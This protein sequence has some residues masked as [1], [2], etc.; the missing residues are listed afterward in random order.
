MT[1]TSAARDDIRKFKNL[2]LLGDIYRQA[3]K[4]RKAGKSS[5]T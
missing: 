4:M 3:V 1:R 2:G 5:C